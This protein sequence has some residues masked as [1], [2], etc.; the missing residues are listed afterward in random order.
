[1]R[2]L[3]GQEYCSL[4]W[5]GAA[6][7]APYHSRVFLVDGAKARVTYPSLIEYHDRIPRSQGGDP[8]DLANQAPLC[9]H[10]HQK[11][12]SQGGYRLTFDGDQV[13]RA[14]GLA[15]TLRLE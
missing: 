13:S 14:D 5:C 6:F 1:M 15:G 4:P 11:H 12:H 7:G 9:I 2:Q 3:D 10:C 8:D